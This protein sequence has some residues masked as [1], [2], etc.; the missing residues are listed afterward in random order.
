MAD[1]NKRIFVTGGTGFLGSY[2]LRYLV[3]MGYTEISALR[4]PSSS[5]ALVA[6]VADKINWIEGDIM[7]LFLLED[8]MKDVQQVYHCAAVVSFDP[9]SYQHMMET[10]QVGTEN[11]V[12]AALYR[13]VDKLVHVSS[14]AA[15]G[16]TK[17]E[18][19]IS[20]Q[21]KWQRSKYNTSYAVSKYLSEQEVWRGIAEGLNANI[22]NPS[23]IMGSGDWN[24]GFLKLFKLAW[25]NFPFYPAGTSG[26]VDVRDVARMMIFLME[27]SIS[28]QRFIA[29][30]DNLTYR[31]LLDQLAVQ[32]N[33]KKP[34]YAVNALIRELS[35][36]LEW[37]R[38][39][40]SS[41]YNP[42]LTKETARNASRSYFYHNEKSLDQ[43]HFQYTPI[44]QTIEETALQFLESSKNDFAPRY[45]PLN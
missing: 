3:Q 22:V 26:F 41:S 18:K 17:K 9:R 8:A 28:S 42:L 13:S 7:D 31:S 36:R 11:V 20:E 29:N 1:S 10:N 38:T 25:K 32:L 15:I 40:F 39:Q 12:N 19:N 23:L 34:K 27:Q 6:P 16:R 43:L 44:E 21:S 2:L 5:M 37:I 35:W 4:R 30:A 33:K 14:I 45:L 24:K